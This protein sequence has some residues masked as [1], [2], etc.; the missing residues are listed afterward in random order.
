MCVCRPS[1]LLFKSVQHVSLPGLCPCSITTIT[2]QYLFAATAHSTVPHCVWETNRLQFTK[3]NSLEKKKA[4]VPV[5]F[6]CTCVIAVGLNQLNRKSILSLI[7][8]WEHIWTVKW[9]RPHRVSAIMRHWTALSLLLL[10]QVSVAKER[11]AL[12]LSLSH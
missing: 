4:P 12:R 5:A 2:I 6:S 7:K 10:F 8:T 9:I 3:G 11:C 1:I